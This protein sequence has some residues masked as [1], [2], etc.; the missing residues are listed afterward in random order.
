VLDGGE[1]LQGA[2][3]LGAVFQ[4]DLEDFFAKA[5]PGFRSAGWRLPFKTAGF[6]NPAT[7]QYRN[8]SVTESP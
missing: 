1:D 3:A 2:T 4:V 7:P 6:C 5:L 8:G